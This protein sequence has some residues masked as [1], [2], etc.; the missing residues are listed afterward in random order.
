MLG[1]ITVTVDYQGQQ[2]EPPLLVVKGSGASL[3][4]RNWLQKIRLDWQGIR[5]LQQIPDL[6]ETLQ[7]KYDDVFDDGLGEINGMEARIDVDT[8]AQPRFC[9]ARPVPFA[10]KDKVEAELERLQRAGIIEPVQSA[11][12][13]AP[14]VPVVKGNGSVRLCGDYRMTVN[15]ASRLDSYPLPKVDELF[16]TLAG[17]P[18]SQS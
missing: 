5:H 1:S 12:W 8:Q 18:F 6:Q 9:K 4:G 2:E 10:L 13:A 17:E 14:I 11:E 15:Q 16:A 7:N 3:L